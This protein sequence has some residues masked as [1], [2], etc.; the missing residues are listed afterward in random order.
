MNSHV[1]PVCLHYSAVSVNSVMFVPFYRWIQVNTQ[2]TFSGRCGVVPV[3]IPSQSS[4]VKLLTVWSTTRFP[5]AAIN[6]L[7]KFVTTAFLATTSLKSWQQT[8]EELT[9]KPRWQLEGFIYLFF[10]S[11]FIDPFRMFTWFGSWQQT[12]KCLW[13][14]ENKFRGLLWAKQ[15]QFSR[16]VSQ[17]RQHFVH[18]W[19]HRCKHKGQSVKASIQLSWL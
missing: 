11:V 10:S 16:T 12:A 18:V 14:E 5:V 13:F 15:T 9:F 6:V 19:K 7:F 2:A 3:Q 4:A 1:V 17:H 8:F